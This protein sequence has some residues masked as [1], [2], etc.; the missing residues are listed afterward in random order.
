MY[1]TSRIFTI[2][3]KTTRKFLLQANIIGLTETWAENQTIKLPHYLQ[4]YKYINNPAMRTHAKERCSGGVILL[5]KDI[6][7]LKDLIKCSNNC[8]IARL[9]HKQS[10][11]TLVVATVYIPPGDKNDKL[12]L[13]IMCIIDS[14]QISED[15]IFGGDFN[16]RTSNLQEFLSD[17]NPNLLPQRLSSDK[18]LNRRG[19]L[20]LDLLEISSLVITNGRT[21]L[22]AL[23][24][25]TFISRNGCSVVDYI[26]TDPATALK[27]IDF[28]VENRAVS[29]HQPITISL[30]PFPGQAAT[31]PSTSTQSTL[32]N[33]A[34][35]KATEFKSAMHKLEVPDVN[36]TTDAQY[37]SLVY[38]IKEQ[39]KQE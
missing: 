24:S 11:H 8:I 19:K 35:N 23:G 4:S 36:A 29:D 12:L 33:W 6:F 14:L 32:L 30:L 9:Q 21:N 2:W 10:K 15:L 13:D 34:P 38:A 16:A 3:I 26:I 7:E 18:E 20:L 5:Y 22:D 28:K 31:T 1:M 17:L 27:I 37:N 39:P 25:P